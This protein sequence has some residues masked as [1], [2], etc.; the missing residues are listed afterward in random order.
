MAVFGVVIATDYGIVRALVAMDKLGFAAMR[1]NTS[2]YPTGIVV[3]NA[4]RSVHQ[5]SRVALN[6]P[7]KGALKAPDAFR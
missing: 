3:A 7:H 2:C 6:S 1:Y 4:D 5:A